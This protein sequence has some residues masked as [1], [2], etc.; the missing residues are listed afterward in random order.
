MHFTDMRQL[1]EIVVEKWWKP[2]V[3]FVAFSEIGQKLS[4][5]IEID[6]YAL[7]DKLNMHFREIVKINALVFNT[8]S[9]FKNV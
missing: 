9:H 6:T 4:F 1:L 7:Q 8:S 3:S 5:P 2:Y